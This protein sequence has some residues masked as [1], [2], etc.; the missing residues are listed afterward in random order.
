MLDPIRVNPVTLTENTDIIPHLDRKGK[1]NSTSVPPFS[2]I[3]KES[4]TRVNDMQAE[5]DRL[6]QRMSLGEV[7]DVSEVSLAVEKA[8]LALRLMLQ[9]RDKLLDAHQQISRMSA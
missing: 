3:L 5:S 4:I 7:E 8:E 2:E 1:G 9:I 6:I